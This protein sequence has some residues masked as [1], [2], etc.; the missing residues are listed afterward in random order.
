MHAQKPCTSA[1]PRHNGALDVAGPIV[2]L[3]G[4][5]GGVGGMASWKC[6]EGGGWRSGWAAASQESPDITLERCW[7]GVTTFNQRRSSWG[8]IGRVVS[9]AS[10]FPTPRAVPS[11]WL[12][13]PLAANSHPPCSHPFALCPHSVF[14]PIGSP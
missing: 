10:F 12:F 14:S 4:V 3:L 2:D 8:S 1:E 13:L 11:A 7:G 6:L 9:A 5:W